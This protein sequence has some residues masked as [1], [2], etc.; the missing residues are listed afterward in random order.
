MQSKTEF[1]DKF[2]RPRSVA[3]VGATAN[4]SKGG[5][6][7]VDNLLNTYDGK[8]F[9]V[10]PA[11]DEIL[12]VPCYP[13]VKD[14][15]EVPDLVIVFVPAARVP[16]V[17]RDCAEGGVKSVLVET[18]GFAEVGGVGLEIQDEMNRICKE[19]GIR[20]WG[21]NCTGLVNTDPMLFTPFMLIPPEALTMP[22]G[23]LAIVAQSGLMAAG[24]MLQ[25]MLSGYCKVSKACSIGNKMDI[26]E[27]DVIGYLG[28]DDT[29]DVVV[30]Y[31][32]SIVRGREFIETAR[33]VSARK[34]LVMIKS[35]RTEVAARA[36]FSHTRSLAGSDKV[37]D[38]ALKQ[39]GVIR[40]DEFLALMAVGKAFSLR[41]EPVKLATPEGNRFAVLT[42]SGGG[43]VVTID[44]A[45]NYGME[46]AQMAPETL[47]R[48]QKEVFPSWMPP[49]N[50]V[51]LWP[52]L[53]EHG[54]D[55][56]FNAIK[57]VIRDPGVDG[58]ILMPYASKGMRTFPYT[59]VKELIEET[60]KA[61]VCWSCGDTRFF[62]EFSTLMGGAGIPIYPDLNTCV[63]VLDAYL[64]Y[65]RFRRDRAGEYGV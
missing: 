7:I 37:A 2:F 14:L 35:G 60:G 16:A 51:D 24:F 63:Q 19:N 39:A 12:G 18:G 1:V 17:L 23:N 65:A 43:G 59:E 31:V 21:P 5:Y 45:A 55:A 58:M 11:Y 13:S 56:F 41:P 22:P 48:L 53:M 29:T 61:V 62:D 34:P 27:T 40:V 28:D 44:L 4:T 30:L 49:E 64:R 9:P 15:P 50:P 33:R 6:T 47:E 42:I 8:V 10:N 3:F 54:R 26:D 38:A 57:L 32:E 36:A 52:A 20:L 46:I 25:Y